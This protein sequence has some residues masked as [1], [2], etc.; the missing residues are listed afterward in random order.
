MRY[1]LRLG[2]IIWCLLGLGLIGIK[3]SID[4]TL[5]R[6]D[7]V[8]VEAGTATYAIP[9]AFVETS[10]WRAD[11]MRVAGCWDAREGGLLPIAASIAGCGGQRSL[12]L[13]IPARSLGP[14]ADAVLRG[15]PMEAVFWSAY[16]PP[17]EHMPQLVNA[18]A[19][20]Y[21]WVG[22]FVVQRDD[23]GLFRLQSVRSPW[24]PLL[25]AEPQ[26][27]DPNELA[28]LYAG[29]CYR[30]DALSD[31]GMACAVALRIEG[32]A[33]IE[34][35]L[36]PDEIAQFGLLREAIAAQAARWAKT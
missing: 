19:G 27:G 3:A 21:E 7:D 1:V 18:W 4:R 12:R 34:F 28:Q 24:V 31:I 17:V 6:Y 8:A 16:Q 32:G 15:Q 20:R 10:G 13:R 5:L 2:L 33:V 30:P 9:R 14:E 29:R 26:T 36:G 23:W 35:S 22:R 11:M 25:I